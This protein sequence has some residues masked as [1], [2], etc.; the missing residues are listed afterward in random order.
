MKE[1]GKTLLLITNSDW[2]YTRC[3]ME[4]AYNRCSSAGS[5]FSCSLLKS[6]PC[7]VIAWSCHVWSLIGF[8]WCLPQ[9]DSCWSIS[10]ICFGLFL[11]FLDL[12]VVSLFSFYAGSYQKA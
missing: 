11:F 1:S 4:F 2:D 8:V 10:E 3:M 5:V 6:K 9:V 7:L 12:G